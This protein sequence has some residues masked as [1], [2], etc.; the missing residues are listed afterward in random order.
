MDMQAYRKEDA[1]SESA[2]H[3]SGMTYGRN[4]ASYSLLAFGSEI[5]RW[6]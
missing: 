6:L 1:V 5:G 3:P 4:E 2:S